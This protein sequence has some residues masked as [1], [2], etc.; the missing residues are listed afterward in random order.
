[1]LRDKHWIGL[2]SLINVCDHNPHRSHASTGQLSD[3]LGCVQ[4]LPLL[5]S[6][7]SGKSLPAGGQ[8]SSFVKGR[9]WLRRTAKRGPVPEPLL[10]V[11]KAETTESQLHSPMLMVTLLHELISHLLWGLLPS[12]SETSK[13]LCSDFSVVMRGY[14]TSLLPS[15]LPSSQG[16]PSGVYSR[17]HT[18][19]I[20]RPSLQANVAREEP[21]YNTF[22]GGCVCCGSGGCSVVPMGSSNRGLVRED[23]G[24]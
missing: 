15:P 2:A 20:M 17:P 11:S 13:L 21:G 12:I 3:N 8:V 1:M 16:P 10:P 4:L 7:P 5:G 18:E 6:S 9:F 19:W 14:I 23:N 24:A 22:V